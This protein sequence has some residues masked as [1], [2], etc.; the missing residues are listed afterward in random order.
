MLLLSNLKTTWRDLVRWRT[1]AIMV[2]DLVVREW[3]FFRGLGSED[4]R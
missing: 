3:D 2:E 1:T 4:M